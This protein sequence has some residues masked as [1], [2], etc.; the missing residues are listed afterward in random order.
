M[1]AMPGMDVDPEPELVPEPEHA[2]F[3]TAPPGAA[4]GVVARCDVASTTVVAASTKTAAVPTVTSPAHHSRAAVPEADQRPTN[5]SS[6]RP[7]ALLLMPSPG[8]ASTPDVRAG[9]RRC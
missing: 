9:P 6:I 5:R 7:I 4:A 1:P 2:G 3:A 8:S